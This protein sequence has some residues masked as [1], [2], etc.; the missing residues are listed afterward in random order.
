M[1]LTYESTL[2]DVC[3]PHI[4]QFLRSRTFRWQRITNSLSAL[5][6]FPAVIIAA[7]YMLG[8]ELAWWIIAPVAIGASL[9]FYF[10]HEALVKDRMR[11]HLKREYADKLPCNT[12]FVIENRQLEC[13]SLNVTTTLSLDDLVS[14]LEDG[15]GIELIFGNPAICV[16][17]LRA[18][19]DVAHKES[20]VGA[21]KPS[22]ET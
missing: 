2:D 17:P 4:R 22:P 19:T 21:L 10:V 8:D 7:Q 3:E 1:K 11:K 15:E 13:T 20:F 12:Q 9:G 16:I 6:V 14:I 5:I 18:F